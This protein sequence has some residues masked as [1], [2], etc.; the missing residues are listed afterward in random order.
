VAGTGSFALEVA[1]WAQASGLRVAGLIELM[2]SDRVGTER[3]G[4]PVIAVAPR[5]PAGRA[6]IGAGGDR[7]AH[8]AAVAEHG[9][10]PVA[11]VHPRAWLSPSVRIGAG[12]V[13]GPNATLGAATQ[14]GDHVL[15]NR[16][17]L[18]GHHVRLEAGAVVNPG[19]NIAGH[20]R[21]GRGATI[22]LGG[23]VADHVDVGVGAVVAAGAVVVRPVAAGQRVQGVPARAWTPA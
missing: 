4:L 19:A 9:W 11:V 6:V 7:R 12:V 20:A 10:E 13:V 8:W 23:V 17:A 1:E 18:I 16:G 3:H 5:P 14:I 21:I 2:D 22:G 15:V